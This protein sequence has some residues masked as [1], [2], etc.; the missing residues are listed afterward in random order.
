MEKIIIVFFICILSFSAFSQ[1]TVKKEKIKKMFELTGSAKSGE[2][3]VEQI[4]TTLQKANPD[5]EQEFWDGCK[6]DLNMGDIVNLLIPIYDKYYTEEDIDQLIK[7]YDTPIGK[8][9]IETSPKISQEML[10]ISM[11]L[12]KGL[13]DKIREKLKTKG[14]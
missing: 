12:G 14:Q 13:S 6:K 1:T 11:G 8:K 10:A 3:L 2:Q 7:F 9:M 5:V 4:I